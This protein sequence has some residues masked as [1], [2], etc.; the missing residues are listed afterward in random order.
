MSLSQVEGQERAVGPLTTALAARAVPHAWL[1]HGPEGVGKEL[2]AVGLAQALTCR[3]KP[4][5]GCG[6]CSS[7]TRV[8]RRGHPDVT[9]V[10]PEDE[11]V[12]RGWAGRSDFTNTPS[13]DIRI[14]QVRSLQERLAFHALEAPHKVALIITAHAMNA[15]AQNALLKTLEEPPRD[16]VLVLVSSA[17]DKLLPTIRSR[18]AKAQFGPLPVEFLTRKLKADRK[19]DDALAAQ[20]AQM[21]GGS[22]ARA[23]ELNVDALAERK[24]IIE[25]F[26]AL[27]PKDARGWLHLAEELGA[28]RPTAEAA[29]DVLQVWQ[30]DVVAAQVGAGRLVNADLADLA[31]KAAARVSAA[32][33]HR[34]VVLIDEA[35]NAIAARNG[36]VRL[37]LERMFIEFFA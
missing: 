18:C 31:V 27:D 33:V 15:S 2:A 13:R 9:W 30:R 35:R 1:F 4:W 17:P 20:A 3:E 28:D 37:Q 5:V 21:A 11:Q 36:A 29:L 12:R 32:S 19:L 16:T 7:C 10:L 22:L 14:E 26:E 25:R 6:T 23:L 34:R 8:A 24:H